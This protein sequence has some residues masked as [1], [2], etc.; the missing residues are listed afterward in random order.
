M[1]KLKVILVIAA[2]IVMLIIKAPIVVSIG[3]LA[4]IY[5]PYY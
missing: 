4:L 3:F 2:A 5:C 1:F